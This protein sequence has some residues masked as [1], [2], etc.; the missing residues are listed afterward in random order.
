VVTP[1]PH[2]TVEMRL[3]DFPNE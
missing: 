2:R 1:Q 3:H